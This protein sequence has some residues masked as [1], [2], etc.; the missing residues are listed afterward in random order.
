M[1]L[2]LKAGDTHRPASSLTEMALLFLFV[3][4]FVL[5]VAISFLDE[6]HEDEVHRKPGSEPEQ[7][8]RRVPKKS[9]QVMA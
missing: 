4:V 3:V 8:S 1:F 9:R 5:C 7:P 6:E 2:T